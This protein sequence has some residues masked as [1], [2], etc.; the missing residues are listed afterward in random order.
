MRPL[1]AEDL[2]PGR[3]EEH[4]P[5]NTHRMEM[6]NRFIDIEAGVW[7]DPL[8]LRGQKATNYLRDVA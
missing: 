1:R 7:L 5:R 4:L 2:D 8:S 3:S 6:R